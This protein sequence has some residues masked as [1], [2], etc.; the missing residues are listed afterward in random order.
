MA[1][2]LGRTRPARPAGR[3]RAGTWVRPRS[4][5]SGHCRG[6]RAGRRL[7]P[8][9]GPRPVPHLCRPARPGDRGGL[10]GRVLPGDATRLEGV[11]AFTFFPLVIFGGFGLWLAVTCAWFVADRAPKLAADGAGITDRTA[12][13]GGRRIPWAEVRG[14]DCRVEDRTGGLALVVYRRGADGEVTAEAINTSGLEGGPAGVFTE[15]NRLW[16]QAAET[17]S[18]AQR[19]VTEPGVS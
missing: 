6:R 1:A 4:G 17:P 14:L 8:V 15:V 10:H 16:L 3:S 11:S 7:P 5:P 2:R 19:F 18:P 9:G 13:N 12:P